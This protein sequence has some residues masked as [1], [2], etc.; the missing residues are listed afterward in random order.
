MV[1]SLNCLYG[2]T[3]MTGIGLK[4]STLM[5]IYNTSPGEGTIDHRRDMSSVHDRWF[6]QKEESSMIGRRLIAGQERFVS[7]HM[8][9]VGSLSGLLVR[10][11]GPA[12]RLNDAQS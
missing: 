7:T 3:R 9:R 12:Q 2:I 10:R 4:C 5:S 6:D 11:Q 8:V 1:R